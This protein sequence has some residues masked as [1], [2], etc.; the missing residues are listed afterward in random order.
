V[1]LVNNMPDSALA[2]TERQFGELLRGALPDREIDLRLFQLDGIGR[3]RDVLEAMAGRYQPTHAIAD[4][5]LA[6]LVVTGAATG[7]GPL[8]DAPYWESF[9]RLVDLTLGLR[10]STLWSC[11]AAHAAV[12]HLDGIGRHALPTKCSGFFRCEPAGPDAL[13]EGLGDGWRVPHSRYNEVRENELAA[14]GYEIL[15]RSDEIGPDVFIKRGPPLF[16]FAQGHMEYDRN[17][18]ALE[19]QRDVR[20]YSQGA[21]DTAPAE[22]VG[23]LD[24][25]MRRTFARLTEAAVA[26]RAPE[27]STV[28]DQ[29]SACAPEWRPFAV[30]LYRNW[31]SQLA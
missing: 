8:R 3:H 26:R 17:A 15:T 18:L 13:L 10:L 2:A 24:A 16:V 20:A 21:R 6:A 11:L 23:A 12:E 29:S 4:A 27:P 1:G 30:G 25:E 22:P 7:T 19:Y 9:T 28:T 31:L 5:G 14:K